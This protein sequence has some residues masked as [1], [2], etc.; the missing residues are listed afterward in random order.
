MADLPG[1]NILEEEFFFSSEKPEKRLNIYI[2][3][4]D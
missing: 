1:V 3:M 4:V 2:I